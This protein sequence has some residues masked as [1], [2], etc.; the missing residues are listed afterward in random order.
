MKRSKHNL[1][2]YNL[3]TGEMGALYPIGAH[4]VLPGDTFDHSVS[5]LIRVSPLNAPVMHPVQVRIHHFFVP[6]RIIWDPWEDFITGGPDGNNADTIPQAIQQ[7]AFPTVLDYMG[8]PKVQGLS[9]NALPVYAYNAIYN[10]F[11]R[12]QDIGPEKPID[13]VNL[14]YCSWEKDYF[15]SARPWEQK[16]D[17]VSIPFGTG[18]AAVESNGNVPRFRNNTD[19]GLA[20]RGQTDG[21][22]R[23]N[24]TPTLASDLT[25]DTETGLRTRLS[26]IDA[27]GVPEL[28]F[29]LAMQKYKEARAM[30]GSRYSEYLAY[31]GVNA[32]DARLN[33]PEY[34]GGGKQNISFSEVLQTAEGVDPVGEMKGHGIA[35]LR[36]NRYRKFFTEHGWVISIMSVRPKSIYLNACHR[37]WYRLDKEDFY[38]KEL[39]LIGQQEIYN[40][41][42]YAQ[43]ATP[44]GVFGY[45]DRY[46]EY[47]E[48]FSYAAGDFINT[49]NHWHM[50]RILTAQ[51]ALNPSFL[52]C[53][54]SKRINADQLSDNLW[55]MVSHRL[56]AR[57]MVRR[58]TVPRIV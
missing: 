11:Y 44:D 51:P 8:V 47:R 21:D 20:L 56:V 58:S 6:N 35:A 16:G 52:A 31:L 33:D 53:V 55:I 27:I 45:G 38:Q 10:R 12:D 32:G 9:V 57:R 54:P 29:G 3:M 22:A 17:A 1:S 18:V 37:K 40:K 28:R 19:T 2:S 43:S 49:L 48:E 42:I 13:N 14:A 46:R 50:G 39:E 26:D 23:I 41:E 4:E 5:S 36:S 25:F 34:L 24:P 30:Y 15:T 7:A